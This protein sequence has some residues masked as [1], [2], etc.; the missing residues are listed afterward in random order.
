[1]KIFL[2]NFS[3]LKVEKTIEGDT[4]KSLS[5]HTNDSTGSENTSVNS[6]IAFNPE[7][8]KQLIKS[9]K[10]LDLSLNYEQPSVQPNIV[11]PYKYTGK[12]RT[13]Y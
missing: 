1:M 13:N 7:S 5:V 9:L 12:N 3:E 6:S 2:T 10:M 11:Y 4:P 8:T